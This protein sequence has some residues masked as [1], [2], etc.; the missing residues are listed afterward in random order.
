MKVTLEKGEYILR[1]KVHWID[2]KEKGAVISTYSSRE[3]KLNKIDLPNYRENLYKFHG[4]TFE[5]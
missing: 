2:K 4:K 3:I 5:D 1:A